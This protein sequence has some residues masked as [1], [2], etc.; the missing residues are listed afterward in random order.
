MTVSPPDP[1]SVLEK[2]I[3]KDRRREEGEEPKER[4]EVLEELVISEDE[5]IEYIAQRGPKMQFWVGAGFSVSSGVPLAQEMIDE[6]T[7]KVFEK[8][9]PDKRGKVTA[10][11][12]Q[13][14]LHR[15]KWFNP[16]YAYASA[17][18]K[19]YPSRTLR[20]EFFE[21]LLDGKDPSPADFYLTIAIKHRKINPLIWTTNFDDLLEKSFYLI[22]R[23][24]AIS[25]RNPD[26]VKLIRDD[27]DHNY[28]VHL[29]GFFDQYEPRYFRQGA[30]KLHDNFI[31]LFDN[32]IKHHGLVVVGY[33]GKEWPAFYMLRH[34]AEDSDE[35]F[36][37]GLLWAHYGDLKDISDIAVRLISTGDFHGKYFRIFQISDADIFMEKLARRLGLPQIEEEL[38][39]SFHYFNVMPYRGMKPREGRVYPSLRDI[40]PSD[41]MDRGFFIEDFNEIF[42]PERAGMSRIFMKK[43][44]KQREQREMHRKGLIHCYILLLDEDFSTAVDRFRVVEER[45]GKNEY[46]SLGLAYGLY[47]LGKFEEA[48]SELDHAIRL[49]EEESKR[50][51][52]KQDRQRVDQRRAGYWWLRAICHEKLSRHTEEKSDYDRALEIVP[53]RADL[54]FN[55]GL[56]ASD[57]DQLG[58]EIQSYERAVGAQSGFVKAWYNLGIALTEAGEFLRA[59][60]A[61]EESSA[62]ARE[63]QGA[64]FNTGRLLGRLGQDYR[65]LNMFQRALE[66]DTND[67]EAIYNLGVALLNEDRH[68]QAKVAFET[69]LEEHPDDL[70]CLNNLG[71]TEHE[72]KEFEQAL[73]FFDRFLEIKD[74]DYRVWYNRAYSLECLE[75]LEEALESY[76][77]SLALNEDSD[78]V[79]YRKSV[80]LGKMGRFQ[81]QV[82]YLERYLNLN[83]EDDRAW[84]D[85]GRA[86]GKLGRY[87][88]EI[89]AYRKALDLKPMKTFIWVDMGIALNKLAQEKEADARKAGSPEERA[90]REE[91]AR[92]LYI[93]AIEVLDTALDRRFENAELWFQKGLA[94]DA[95]GEMLKANE[96]YERAI[97]LDESHSKSYF[98]RGVNL[99]AL[100]QFAKAIDM[101]NKVIELDPNSVAAWDNKGLAYL[102]MKEFKKARETFEEAIEKFPQNDLLWLHLAYVCAWQR[103][104]EGVA[105]ALRRAL[106]LNPSHREEVLREDIFRPLL[107]NPKVKELVG[108]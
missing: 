49:N 12:L 86:L 100:E 11:D 3:R 70:D 2:L 92:Q 18:E 44:E 101:F 1:G 4:K 35:F 97:K 75:R 34:A 21:K 90:G 74:D 67:F 53:G 7:V 56:A 59:M 69:Y 80:L 95:L 85:Y 50:Q 79:W 42:V 73:K 106:E 61:F 41:L 63:L 108:A 96:C 60:K 62:R 38:S 24:S 52:I 77:R 93:K 103:D 51:Q 57:L 22:R 40:G 32:R 6:I 54:W 89:E 13:E 84:Y 29:Y 68:E 20:K 58:E 10:A 17:L 65:A 71:L 104:A 55:R 91:E 15:Q 45:F 8:T 83:S 37:E 5:A 33:S 99:A 88:E 107:H 25:I 105:E 36:S 28:I 98:N 9:N 81:E 64:Y 23:T 76:D 102:H 16:D 26:D 87:Q 27:E 47:R 31:E 48:I 72:L 30:V 66:L 82:E 43:E 19:E 46:S 39:V 14:W 78:L 94:Y